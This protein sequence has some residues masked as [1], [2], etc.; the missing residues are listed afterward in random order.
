PIFENLTI[1]LNDVYPLSPDAIQSKRGNSIPILKY[2][3]SD[4]AAMLVNIKDESKIAYMT[5][6][7]EQISSVEI[8]NTILNSVIYW[9]DT[10]TN[11]VKENSNIPTTYSLEQ[12]FPNPFNPST[13]ISYQIKDEGKVQIKIFDVLGREIKVLVNETKQPGI[14]SLTYNANDLNSGVYFYSIKVNDFMSTKKM[15]LLK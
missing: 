5:F 10:P 13:T 8:R 7:L 11:V 4:N 1:E 9:F 12:N 3:D 14:Y 6:G 2:S 15:I